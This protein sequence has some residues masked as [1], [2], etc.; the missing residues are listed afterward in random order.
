M[1][2]Q[3][4]FIRT[5]MGALVKMRQIIRRDYLPKL[6]ERAGFVSAYL[7]E[8]VD[9][10]DRA[11]LVVLW[12]NQAALERSHSTG[13]LEA[14]VHGL[15]STLPGVEIQRQGYVLTIVREGSTE[16]LGETR[17]TFAQV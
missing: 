1:Y 3:I 6:R 15:A 9:D 2:S 16:E 12:E 17:H 7:M 8:Q 5:P 4:T 10:P 11:Q 13:A 14:S